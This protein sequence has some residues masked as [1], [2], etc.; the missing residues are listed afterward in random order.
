MNDKRPV[1][2][3]VTALDV[4]SAPTSTTIVF[5]ILS[6]PS[7]PST[8]RGV[9]RRGPFYREGEA[10]SSAF[11]VAWRELVDKNE[12]LHSLD[13]ALRLAA[14]FNA[15][16]A[17]FD[18]VG[19]SRDIAAPYANLLGYDVAA[20]GRESVLSWGIQWDAARKARLPLGPLLALMERYFRPK[21]NQ[22]GLFD[23]R[24]TGNMFCD[25]LLAIQQLAPGTW[26]APGHYHPEVLAVFAP[27]LASAG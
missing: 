21:L 11:N 20:N 26:E 15:T 13:E 24:E 3:P 12:T 8:Y 6:R 22:Y 5:Q 19:I 18:V 14:V 16:H 25:V 2:E 7:P 17:A 23:E 9:G 10:E 1:H 27:L 4:S